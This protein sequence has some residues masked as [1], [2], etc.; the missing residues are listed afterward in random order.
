MVGQHG[1]HDHA[2]AAAPHRY[3]DIKNDG[4]VGRDEPGAFLEH[5]PRKVVPAYDAGFVWVSL[6]HVIA[7]RAALLAH[8]AVAR[9][10]ELSRALQRRQLTLRASHIHSK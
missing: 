4:D 7:G 8:N 1:Q 2:A 9:A 3:A 10:I 5:L 6:R